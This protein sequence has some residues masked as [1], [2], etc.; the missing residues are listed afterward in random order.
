MGNFNK[1]KQFGG[2]DRGRGF[3]GRGRSFGGRSSFGGGRG[4]DRPSM[5]QAVCG[6]CGQECEVPFKPTGSRPV[7][8]SNCFEKQKGG[9]DRRGGFGSER[10]ERPERS[11]R[12]DREDKQMFEVVCTKC[13]DKC[14]VPFKPTP[15]KPVF[16]DNCFDKG[17]K[18]GADYSEQFKM[19][20]EKL[21]K[22]IRVLA[23]KTSTSDIKAPEKKVA[24]EI[25]KK[26]EVKEVK[27]TSKA[28][29]AVKKVAGKKK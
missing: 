14:Q 9:D 16:C 1:G 15:G 28:K 11:F 25:S 18:G 26:E 21:D 13:G 23:P 24:K 3:G 12:L 19:L 27:K 29:P 8:C 10:R 7:F 22:L 17:G 6:E 5:H 20:N 2:G 4:G